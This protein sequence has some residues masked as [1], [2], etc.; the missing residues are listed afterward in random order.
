MF[1]RR[2]RGVSGP[3]LLD[4][5]LRPPESAHSTL[6][7]FSP[8]RNRP[9]VLLTASLSGECG[10]LV[11]RVVLHHHIVEDQPRS[12]RKGPHCRRPAMR[13]PHS[14]RRGSV[15]TRRWDSRMCLGR[16]R[17][18]GRCRPSRDEREWNEA[19]GGFRLERRRYSGSG[20]ERSTLPELHEQVDSPLVGDGVEPSCA[21]RIGRDNPAG[22]GLISA[23]RS[24]YSPTRAVRRMVRSPFAPPRPLPLRPRRG[25]PT[26]MTRAR[27]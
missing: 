3:L 21:G 26:S 25:L 20:A 12:R 5:S 24:D 10:C 27:R 1:H 14:A 16:T 2:G 8:D 18:L 7:V 23:L 17:R 6:R 4:R 15:S 13:P 22:D 9:R 19:S 11:V